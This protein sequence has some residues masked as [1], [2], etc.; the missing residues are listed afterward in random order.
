ML[1]RINA[2]SETYEQALADAGVPYQ[3]RGAERFFERPEVREAGVLLRGAAR[4]GG[5][6]ALPRRRRGPALPGACRAV[7]TQ[8]WT[9]EPPGGLGAV[10]DRWESLAA[11]VRLAEDFAAASPGR[12][13]RRPRRGARRAGR[14]PST[15]RPSRASPSPRCTRPRAWS[16]TPSSWSGSPRA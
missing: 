4:V 9:A 15:P 14:A 11:L 3:L 12:D 1:F 16:G 5:N 6:D 13:A 2:Q 7:G 8:G 10:R